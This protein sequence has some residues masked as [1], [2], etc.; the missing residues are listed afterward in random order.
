MLCTVALLVTMAPVSAFAESGGG[1][2][3]LL[4]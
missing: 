3:T 1:V 4:P 2:L